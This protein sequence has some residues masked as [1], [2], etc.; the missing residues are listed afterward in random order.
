MRGTLGVV[1]TCYRDS[2]CLQSTIRDYFCVDVLKFD[3]V[4]GSGEAEI[5]SITPDGADVAFGALVEDCRSMGT[6]Q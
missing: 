6:E 3:E 1:A 5:K 4:F 2:L